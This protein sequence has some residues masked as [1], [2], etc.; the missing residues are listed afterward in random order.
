MGFDCEPYILLLYRLLFTLVLEGYNPRVVSDTL[1]QWS[2]SYFLFAVIIQ[3]DDNFSNIFG[4]YN[5]PH[6]Y[7]TTDLFTFQ[8]ISLHVPKVQL[9]CV[10]FIIL[11]LQEAKLFS[12]Y[13][14][15][16][17]HFCCHLCP[18]FILCLYSFSRPALPKQHIL[19]ALT[20]EIYSPNA[21][22]EEVWNQDVGRA[23]LCLGKE[24]S[25]HL[26]TF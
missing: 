25:F 11:Y 24:P 4:R 12:I 9:Y 18:Q 3:S 16:C 17:C 26:P 1:F 7:E 2:E 23:I 13:A 14:H 8:P 20:I 19:C 5:C 10:D 15:F 22:D 6:K 21:Q